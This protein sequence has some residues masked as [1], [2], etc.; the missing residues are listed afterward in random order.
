MTN[1]EREW[2]KMREGEVEKLRKCRPT[3]NTDENT[4]EH[5]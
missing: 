4:D 3:D 2:E 1:Y 5:R